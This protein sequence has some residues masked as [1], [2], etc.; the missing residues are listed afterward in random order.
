MAGLFWTEK[1]ILRLFRIDEKPISSPEGE[2]APKSP[3]ER[4]R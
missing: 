3:A 4:F 1:D 2:T